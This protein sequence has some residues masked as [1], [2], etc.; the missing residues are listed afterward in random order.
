MGCN[1]IQKQVTLPYVR[2]PNLK[3]H[4]PT[5]SL[6]L[7]LAGSLPFPMLKIWK[8]AWKKEDSSRKSQS[9]ED[10]DQ[11]G[12]LGGTS[13]GRPPLD[14]TATFPP[15]S[16]DS[17]LVSV[18]SHDRSEKKRLRTAAGEDSVP[19]DS[20][21]PPTKKSRIE[22]RDSLKDHLP[23]ILESD[24][25]ISTPP[26]ASFEAQILDQAKRENSEVHSNSLWA[27]FGG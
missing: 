4:N 24:E 6:V 11:E 20:T 25:P 13:G 2:V 15:N 17:L 16:G 27:D 19:N 7:H 8:Q 5:F 23:E 14:V 9:G 26:F 18:D 10:S 3:F 21:D 1:G 22:T 12:Q